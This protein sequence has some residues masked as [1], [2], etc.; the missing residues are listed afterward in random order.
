MTDPSENQ[1]PKE[2]SRPVDNE[3]EIDVD[4]LWADIEYDWPGYN[5]EDLFRE[6]ER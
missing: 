2:G 4:S 1:S 6:E 5:N 3:Y